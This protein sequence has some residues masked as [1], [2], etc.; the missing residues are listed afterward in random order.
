[1]LHR[2]EKEVMVVDG[3]YQL[4]IPFKQEHPAYQTH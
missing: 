3:H 1:M 2:W 4:L